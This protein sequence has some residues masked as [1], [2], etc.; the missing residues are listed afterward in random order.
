MSFPDTLVAP[1][2]VAARLGDPDLVVLDCR[3]ALADA[4]AGWQAY[5]RSHLP[6]A[7]YAHLDTDLSDLGRSG[8]G[9]H[10]LPDPGVFAAI[11]GRWGIGPD[12]DVACYDD[13]G[14]ALAA[15]RAWWLLRSCGHRRVAVIDGGWAAWTGAGLPVADDK[16]PRKIGDLPMLPSTLGRACEEAGALAAAL[17]RGEILLLDARAGPRF[18]GEVEPIDARAGHVPGA[19]NRPYSAN[20]AA[21]G[22][23]LPA[24]ELRR[25]FEALLQGRAPSQVVHMC[26]SGVTAVHN[27]LAMEHAGLHGSRLYAPSW[28]GWITDPARPVATGD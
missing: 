16:P 12:T 2:G 7:R 1:A 13:A 17:A 10:P 28:S 21:D 26:G 24:A 23:F 20:L 14:G 15:A 5:G 11:C 9:R 3:Y 25:Q 8:L 6:G 18:R 27:L 19:R 4:N 22:G